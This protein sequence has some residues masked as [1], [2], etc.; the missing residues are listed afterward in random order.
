MLSTGHGQTVYY[1]CTSVIQQNI[2]EKIKTLSKDSFPHLPTE[3]PTN[4]RA[5]HSKNKLLTPHPLPI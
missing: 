2:V 3:I 1:K 4:N 5:I